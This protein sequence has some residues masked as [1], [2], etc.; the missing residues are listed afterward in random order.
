MASPEAVW[1]HWL[2]SA[3]LTTV[4]GPSGRS[5]WAALKSSTWACL[6]SGPVAVVRMWPPVI[7]VPENCIPAALPAG[8]SGLGADEPVP[9][10]AAR[11]GI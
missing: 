1:Y 11:C 5:Y 6:P 2:P 9:G 7:S 8:V 3:A 4:W 10:A